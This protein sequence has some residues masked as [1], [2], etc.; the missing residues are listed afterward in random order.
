MLLI[1]KRRRNSISGTIYSVRCAKI[2]HKYWMAKRTIE[3]RP[4]AN[5]NGFSVAFFALLFVSFFVIN[6][7]P[8]WQLFTPAWNFGVRSTSFPSLRVFFPC[9]PRQSNDGWMDIHLVKCDDDIINY[10]EMKFA[11]V[12][13]KWSR[14]PCE[15]PF[16]M[17]CRRS[18]IYFLCVCV[19]SPQP[20]ARLR[21][22]YFRFIIFIN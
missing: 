19:S 6:F 16:A 2:F 10:Y 11:F 8:N 5:K 7:H 13:R 12:C 18:F 20:R 22:F 17:S 21:C 4:I 9:R 1:N 15:S 3:C 14:R